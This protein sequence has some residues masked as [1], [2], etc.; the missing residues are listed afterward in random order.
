MRVTHP[1]GPPEVLMR[2][3]V[4]CFTAATVLLASFTTAQSAP[5]RGPQP[6]GALRVFL[7]CET[8]GC[9][10]DFFVTEIPYVDFIRD[11]VANGVA[12]KNRSYFPNQRGNVV[13]IAGT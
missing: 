9:D 4:M 2:L 7:D 11:R 3:R 5:A 12:I 13:V 8:M 10:T 1:H 6:T